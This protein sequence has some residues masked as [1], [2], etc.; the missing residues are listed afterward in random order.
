MM[1]CAKNFIESRDCNTNDEYRVLAGY[2]SPS[3]DIMGK[4]KFWQS[5]NWL[6]VQLRI[7]LIQTLL[8]DY[9]TNNVNVNVN[10]SS[11]TVCNMYQYSDTDVDSWLCGDYW[12]CNQNKFI[13]FPFVAQSMYEKLLKIYCNPQYDMSN[14]NNNID[15]DNNNVHAQHSV[16]YKTGLINR[17]QCKFDLFYVCGMDHCTKYHLYDGHLLQRYNIKTI[18]VARPH[19]DK[20][21]A[22]HGGK[23]IGQTDEAKGYYIVQSIPCN[24][25]RS[26]TIVREMIR[27]R[28]WDAL[29]N[30]VT[31]TCIKY[32]KDDIETFDKYLKP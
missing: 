32:Y 19:N 23:Y 8:K 12:E 17:E 9:E 27:Q 13:D 28:D 15:N 2:V 11:K 24:Y 25:D 1:I 26:S 14:A 6:P 10:G 20:S 16:D 18:A 3:H 22:Q 4:Y 5:Y 31:P 21:S 30:Y 7:N 29:K